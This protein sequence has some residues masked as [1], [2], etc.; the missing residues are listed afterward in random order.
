[1]NSGNPN[2]VL[3]PV[4]MVMFFSAFFSIILFPRESYPEIQAPTPA[5][6]VLEQVEQAY[7]AH[8]LE[9]AQDICE[10]AGIFRQGNHFFRCWVNGSSSYR[11]SGRNSSAPTISVAAFRSPAAIESFDAS[12]YVQ[13]AVLPMF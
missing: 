9:Q 11:P 3:V 1:M 5:E 13:R 7:W 6:E 2:D 12:E 10:N 8:G 4:L